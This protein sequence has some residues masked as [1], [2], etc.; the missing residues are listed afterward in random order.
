MAQLLQGKKLPIIS[1]NGGAGRN[2]TDDK[3]FAV[4]GLTTWLPR[5]INFN[6][7]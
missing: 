3:G 6:L 2:R 7:C 5:L 4:L 1:K